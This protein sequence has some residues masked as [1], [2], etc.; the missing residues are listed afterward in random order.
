M[1][2]IPVLLLT[3]VALFVGCDQNNPPGV[4]TVPVGVSAGEIGIA[5]TFLSSATDPDSDQVAIR[6]DWGDGNT[7]DWTS[8]VDGGVQ[9]GKSHAWQNAGTFLVK[10]QAKDAKGKTSD[11]SAACSVAISAQTVPVTVTLTW[12]ENP[13]DLDAHMWTP[14]IGGTAYHVYYMD[15]G[16]LSTAPYCSLDVDDQTSYGPEHMLMSQTEPG[17]YV[18]AV[19]HYAGSGTITT[20]GAKVQVYRQGQPVQSFDVP[21]GPSGDEWWWHVFEMDGA[22]RALTPLNVIDSVPPRPFTDGGIPKK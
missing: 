15:E 6:F 11:W 20:S 12:G 17:T 3:V 14:N 10:A 18:F 1:R 21:T 4:P 5:Y 8:L 22:T 9:V 19:H 7:S 16:S 2:H 13:S